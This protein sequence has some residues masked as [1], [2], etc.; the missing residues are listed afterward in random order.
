MNL[1]P[2]KVK[3]RVDNTN[4]TRTLHLHG[5]TES[6]AIEKLYSTGAVSKDRRIIILSIEPL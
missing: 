2:Y 3:F 6:E 4:S 1:K 5:G